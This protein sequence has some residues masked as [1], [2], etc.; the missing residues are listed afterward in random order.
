MR[1]KRLDEEVK[2][3]N[4]LIGRLL[5]EQEEDEDE[6]DFPDAPEGEEDAEEPDIEKEP[7][8]GQDTQLEV[9]FDNLDA[10]SQKVFMDALRDNLNIANDDEYAKNKLVDALSKEPIATFRAEDVVRK[11]NIDI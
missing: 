6:V 9:Y 1:N 5:W 10:E 8:Q 3:A 11:L 7:E 4:D 2:A